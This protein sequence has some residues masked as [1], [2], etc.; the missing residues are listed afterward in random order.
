MGSGM[1]KKE[2]LNFDGLYTENMSSTIPYL[3][4][5]NYDARLL[6]KR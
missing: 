6:V 1:S 4:R 5:I 3:N 2:D